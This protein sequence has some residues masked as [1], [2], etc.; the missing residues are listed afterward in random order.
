MTESQ[1]EMVAVMFTDV[2]GYSA[3]AQQN[4]ALALRLL[5]IK[6]TIADPVITEYHGHLIKT[7]G[8]A[9]MVEFK[10]ALDA[11]RCAATLQQRL[12]EHNLVVPAEQQ[13]SV[14]IGVH[15]G[16]VVRKDGDIFG[17]TV[18]IAARVE[19]QAPPGGIAVTHA[20]YEQ[21]R[22]KFELPLSGLGSFH[23]KGIEGGTVLYAVVLPW[24]PVH[25][26]P[27]RRR[28]VPLRLYAGAGVALLAVV[29]GL[30]L[31]RTL[32]QHAASSPGEVPAAATVAPPQSVAVLPFEN[33]SGD[34][35]NAYFSAGIQDEVLTRL[36]QV[37]A[38][39]VVSRTSTLKYASHPENLKTVGVELGVAAVLEGSVQRAGDTA[40]VNVQLI[41]AATDTHLWAETYDRSLKDIF[42]AENDIA[43]KIADALKAKLK[44]G[45]SARITEIPTHDA[46]AYDLFLQAE[47]Q[48]N[49]IGDQLLSGKDQDA[50][51]ARAIKLY[52]AAIARDPGFTLA[53]ARRSIMESSTYFISNQPA[54]AHLD[55]DARRDAAKALALDPAS[56]PAHLAMGFVHYYVE[57][58]YAKALV[59][60]AEAAKVSPNDPALIMAT[61]MVHRRRGEFDQAIQGFTQAAALD[62]ANLTRY[63]D[64]GEVC[65]MILGR[66]EDASAI[67]DRLAALHPDWITQIRTSRA[68]IY[69]LEGRFDEA[70]T[71]M[72]TMPAEYATD[73]SVVMVRYFLARYRRDS[74]G[75]LQALSSV[76]E[77]YIDYWPVAVF[78][79]DAYAMAHDD[80]KA[81]VEW[82][83]ADALLKPLQKTEADNPNVWEVISFLEAS[84]GN[85]DAAIE[86]GRR[87]VALMPMSEDALNGPQYLYD[88]A[89]AEARVGDVPHAL[90]DLETL[91]SRPYGNQTSVPLLRI[92][93]D[94][95]RVRKDPRFDALLNKY[96]AV[97]Y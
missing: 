72:R 62:P 32:S 69:N 49:S 75:M 36:A 77:T 37:G 94:W 74:A 42:S 81:K 1:R 71:Q 60:Y 13:I 65:D 43:G 93:P 52:D 12:Y 3:L 8:D 79:G 48:A 57:R 97:K 31:W 14:R 63:L 20:V 91:L 45:E 83:E 41:D 51:A 67:V 22:N 34:P 18:N 44:P 25:P 46:V 40:R 59:E 70:N 30:G 39:K 80:A 21:I 73:E 5:E 9:L 28:A 38:L 56:A 29:A 7:I 15:M 50:A 96:A 24:G 27:Q 95:D 26:Q 4:E 2:S 68:V 90:R 33:L 86:A 47:Y 54:A 10:S 66:Y 64:F 78:R 53:Y 89:T 19:P 82:A 76:R 6:R 35:N 87:G 23:L 84:R 17:D 92:D 11:A 55:A 61:A 16:D 85:R 88:L 58:D